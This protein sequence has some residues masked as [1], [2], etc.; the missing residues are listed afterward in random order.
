M[1]LKKYFAFQF[2]LGSVVLA[3]LTVLFI[4]HEIAKYTGWESIKD[5]SDMDLIPFIIFSACISLAFGVTSKILFG[6]RKKYK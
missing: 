1:S 5:F 6:K 4:Y 2:A 3:I